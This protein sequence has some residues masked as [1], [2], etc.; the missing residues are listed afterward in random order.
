MTL[1]GK[2]TFR[3]IPAFTGKESLKLVMELSGRVNFLGLTFVL[4]IVFFMPG[5]L[6]YWSHVAV[7]AKKES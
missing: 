4:L 6:I 1:T 7:R 5:S 2:I 3:V